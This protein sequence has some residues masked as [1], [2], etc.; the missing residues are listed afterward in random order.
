[1][2]TALPGKL[3]RRSLGVAT[4]SESFV[5]DYSRLTHNGDLSLRTLHGGKRDHVD[6]QGEVTSQIYAIAVR[7]LCCGTARRTA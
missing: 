1:M 5:S 7:S 6:A 3:L 2:F 4:V